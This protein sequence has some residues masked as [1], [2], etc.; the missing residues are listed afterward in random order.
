MKI[1]LS[2]DSFT[3]VMEGDTDSLLDKFVEAYKRLR[4]EHQEPADAVSPTRPIGFIK[5]VFDDDEEL[6][7]EYR[8]PLI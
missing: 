3:L 8:G 5:T 1:Q 4:Q 2:S 7:E 6:E